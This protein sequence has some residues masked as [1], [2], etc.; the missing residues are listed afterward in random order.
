MATGTITGTP[1]MDETDRNVLDHFK[2]GVGVRTIG[3]RTGLEVT[4]VQEIIN[5]V[6]G[7]DRTRAARLVTLYDQEHG[8]P[9]SAAAVGETFAGTLARSTGKFPPVI[10]RLATPVAPV[11]EPVDLA[12]P[13]PVDMPQQTIGDDLDDWEGLDRAMQP[14]IA[15]AVAD[16]AELAHPT[17][18]V[19]ADPHALDDLTVLAERRALEGPRDALP[20]V[21]SFDDLMAAADQAGLANLAVATRTAVD[22]LYARYDHERRTRMIRADAAELRAQLD[23]R[24]AELAG[25]TGGAAPTTPAGADTAGRRPMPA[26]LT[27]SRANRDAIRAWANTTGRW[28]IADRGVIPR[29][30]VV[31]WWEATGGEA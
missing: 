28:S 20:A 24:L 3:L 31:E 16:L 27:D 19:A 14:V 21:H 29:A 23:I 12:I 9:A 4:A 8:A 11:V 5:T 18:D 22:N 13:A 25:L 17:T 1:R 15:Q 10:E 2:E 7:G 30:A 26:D 6:A